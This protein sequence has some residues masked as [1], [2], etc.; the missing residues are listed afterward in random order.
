MFH[1]LGPLACYDSE[2][3]S[4]TM[5]TFRHFGRT[6]WTGDRL[7]TMTSTYTEQQDTRKKKMEIYLCRKRDKNPR[8]HCSRGPRP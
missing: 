7:K 1:G 2:L 3:T 5:N 6:P 4:G 8:S